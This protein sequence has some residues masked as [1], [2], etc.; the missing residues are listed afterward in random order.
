MGVQCWLSVAYRIV[1]LVAPSG[2]PAGQGTSEGHLVR[3]EGVRKMDMIVW[4][5]LVVLIVV[6]ILAVA[7]RGRM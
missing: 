1:D 2:K 6:L 5:L 7:G 3:R 4:I